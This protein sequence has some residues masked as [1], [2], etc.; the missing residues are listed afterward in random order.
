MIL[1]IGKGT[2]KLTSL[3]GLDKVYETVIDFSKMSDTWDLGYWEK[4]EEYPIDI[5]SSP[6]LEQIQEKLQ[7]LIPAYELP[8]PAFSAKKK[9][10]KR[11][12]QMARSG[13]EISETRIMKVQSFKI[14]EYV[15][16]TL[17]LR[18]AVGSGTYIRSIGYWLGQQ[19][20]LGGILTELKRVSLGEWSLASLK[21]PEEVDYH[22]RGQ[23]GSFKWGAIEEE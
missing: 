16:P 19:F 11:L 14:L 20:K 15:F 6:T 1:G 9:E 21:M 7:L 13:Q 2:K 10:G 22:M 4:Y 23:V 12:Y 3:I 5:A 8:L 17:R 18:L